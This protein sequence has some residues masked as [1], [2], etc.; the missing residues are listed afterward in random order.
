MTRSLWMTTSLLYKHFRTTSCILSGEWRAR[1]SPEMCIC[2]KDVIHKTPC[3]VYIQLV[4]A[5]RDSQL[6][7]YNYRF[8]WNDFLG[9]LFGIRG[10][11]IVPKINRSQDMLDVWTYFL[12]NETL[13]EKIMSPT[14]IPNYR[15]L[16]S[17]S[18]KSY[19]LHSIIAMQCLWCQCKGPCD[20]YDVT[21]RIWNALTQTKHK[22]ILLIDNC[23]C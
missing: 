23:R 22:P 14:E 19:R 15:F 17:R 18:F 5:Y 11:N 8:L 13:A 2:D 6:S 20:K 9:I 16:S 1:I 10:K 12:C 7:Y 21:W 3:H 4:N